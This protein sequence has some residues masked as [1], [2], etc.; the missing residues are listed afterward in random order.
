M[1][2]NSSRANREN[3]ADDKLSCMQCL[4]K[5]KL[6][7]KTLDNNVW[8]KTCYFSYLF[9]ENICC[10]HSLKYLVEAIPMYTS[11]YALIINK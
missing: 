1:S 4:F 3:S 5:Y 2:F 10:G 8:C 11:V 7:L 9:V 6:E